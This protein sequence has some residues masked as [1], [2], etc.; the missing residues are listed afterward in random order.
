MFFHYFFLKNVRHY[1]DVKGQVSQLFYNAV[2][3]LNKLFLPCLKGR[4]ATAMRLRQV[5][6][7]NVLQ[8][9]DRNTLIGREKGTVFTR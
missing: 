2:T 9:L 4:E 7:K 5:W 8:M 1:L 3:P 6:K